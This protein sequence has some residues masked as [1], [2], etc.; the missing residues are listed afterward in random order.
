M[1]IL[2]TG[3]SGFICKA[4]CEKLRQNKNFEVFGIDLL[5]GTNT[6]DLLSTNEKY[7]I[8]YHFAATNG[9]KLFY[10]KPTEVLVNNTLTSIDIYNYLSKNPK[11]KVVFSSTCE[12]FNGAIDEGIYK[13]PTDEE[14]PIFFK[15]INNP[16]WSYSLPKALGENLFSNIG[17]DYLNLRF[18]NIFG[19]DQKDHF[20]P[21]FIQRIKKDKKAIIYGNDTRSFCYIDDTIEILIRLLK[22]NVWNHTLNIGSDY[23]V[24]I[25]E[26]AKKIMKI[27]GFKNEL[28]IHDSPEGSVKRRKPDLTKLKRLLGEFKYTN[29]DK[30]LKDTVDSYV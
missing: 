15:D 2:V 27:L 13:I 18:F 16:R 14:V 22:L 12:I 29:F 4:L 7:D 20:I 5:E 24:S 9:T 19:P 25:E 17:N 10:E 6:S 8:I 30:S 3:S 11:T 28:I 21:E 1:K 26:V 23:E